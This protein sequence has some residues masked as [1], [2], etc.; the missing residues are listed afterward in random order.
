MDEKR[1]QRIKAKAWALVEEIIDNPK[2]QEYSSEAG[3][4]ARSV[5]QGELQ[6]ES[7]NIN[8]LVTEAQLQSAKEKARLVNPPKLLE[9]KDKAANEL[10]EED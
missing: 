5:I 4:T 3:R 2:D 8:I 6:R 7:V 10:N 9:N 1:K